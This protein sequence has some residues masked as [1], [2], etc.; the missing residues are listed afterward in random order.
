M[1]DRQKKAKLRI[2]LFTG[3]LIV[4]AVFFLMFLVERNF[5]ISYTETDSQ[6]H[7]FL[8]LIGYAMMIFSSVAFIIYARQ[9]LKES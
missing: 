6:S 2:K 7:A 8:S 9:D 1:T 3:L 4:Q 5:Q